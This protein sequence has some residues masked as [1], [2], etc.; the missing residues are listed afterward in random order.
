MPVSVHVIM[1]N[2]H[3]AAHNAYITLVHLQ[4]TT[5]AYDITTSPPVAPAIR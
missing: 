1:I 5:G 3:K 4:L 2:L